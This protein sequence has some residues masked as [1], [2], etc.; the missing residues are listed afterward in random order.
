[1]K[2][3]AKN[4]GKASSESPK[5]SV[6]G[7]DLTSPAFLLELLMIQQEETRAQKEENHKLLERIDKLQDQLSLLMRLLH[8]S[9]SEKRQSVPVM[10]GEQQSLFADSELSAELLI[11]QQEPLIQPEAAP[12]KRTLKT[13]RITFFKDLPVSQTITLKPDCDLT[14]AKL[15]GTEI[16]TLLTYSPAI[17]S[18]KEYHREKYVLPTDGRIVIADMPSLPI[19]KGEVDAT[20]LAH[21]SVSKFVDHLPFHRQSK[22]MAREGIKI[23]ESTMNGWFD[24]TCRLLEILY[25]H[26]RKRI[27]ESRYVQA[28]ET[29]IPVQTTEKVGATHKGFLWGFY[30]PPQGLVCF[31]YDKG[32]GSNVPITFLEH[33]FGALQTDGYAAYNVVERNASDRIVH[34]ACLAHIRRYFDRALDNDPDRANYALSEIGKLYSIEREARQSEMSIEERYALRQE[35]AV[36]VLNELKKWLEGN[37]TYLLPQSRI[38]EAF[39]YT[40]K[41]WD[42]LMNYTTSG[43][44]NIDNNPIENAIRSAALGRR[45]WMFAGS[46]KGAQRAAMMYSFFG[47]CKLHEVNPE[48]WLADVLNRLPD[49]SILKL[50]ELLPNNWKPATLK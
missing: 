42:R 4:I 36:P 7:G 19:T 30:S 11:H 33:F 18:L 24:R 21:I 16:T 38:G 43:L 44:Y 25:E 13:G 15:I 50:D 6:S 29:T 41:L 28:D 32:R 47:S 49:H 8:G 39:T 27:I 40:L 34:L 46:H 26:L 10:N 35:K 3:A 2:T 31:I 45:N 22:M 1:M 14:G 5:T 17:Y 20:V 23:A 12:K 37:A 9:K 48:A